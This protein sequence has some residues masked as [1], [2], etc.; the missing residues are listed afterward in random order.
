[1]RFNATKKQVT[2]F[3]VAAIAYEKLGDVTSKNLEALGCSTMQLDGRRGHVLLVAETLGA[4]GHCDM[5][6]EHRIA[7]RAALELHKKECK[8]AK[9][10]DGQLELVGGVDAAQE[11][12]DEVDE[13]LADIDEQLELQP[14]TEEE[15]QSLGT[16]DEFIENNPSDE[17]DEKPE[18]GEL[19]DHAPARKPGDEW[20]ENDRSYIMLRDG[21]VF[22]IT[23]ASDKD[24]KNL[25]RA[26]RRKSR[27][28]S[29]AK[30]N[31]R[32]GASKTG[33]RKR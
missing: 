28:T 1:M 23:N 14:E 9:K 13:F 26:A 8:A 5:N 10:K 15:E 11:R 20:I 33:K 31:S 7:A 30:V 16:L 2:I 21:K 24:R 29:S 32:N 3:S 25:R 12:M 17:S 18:A 19:L 4:D 27:S 6:A 22:D